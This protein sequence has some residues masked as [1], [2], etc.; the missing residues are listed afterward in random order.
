LS[1]NICTTT[2]YSE[3]ITTRSFGHTII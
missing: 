3:D 1:P 2:N